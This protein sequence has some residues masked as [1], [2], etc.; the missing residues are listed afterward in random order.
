ME[1]K[2]YYCA[3][4]NFTSYAAGLAEELNK[5]SGFQAVIIEGSKGIFDVVA[6]GKLVFSRSETGRLPEPGE[7]IHKLKSP[8]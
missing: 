6:D 7:I 1:I 4:W 3:P 5:T 2:I 8:S